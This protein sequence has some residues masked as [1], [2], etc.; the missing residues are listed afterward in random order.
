MEREGKRW[1]HE[2]LFYALS[3]DDWLFVDLII[4]MQP[5]LFWSDFIFR[6][7]SK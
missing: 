6:L 1:L 5:A 2:F 4:Q 7:Y 3:R